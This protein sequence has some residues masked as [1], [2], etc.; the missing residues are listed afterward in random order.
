MI[1]CNFGV[2]I[3]NI[4][5]KHDLN[6]IILPISVKVAFTIL[7]IAYPAGAAHAAIKDK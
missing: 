2:N 4:V 7:P 1:C 5:P 3:R 6:Y